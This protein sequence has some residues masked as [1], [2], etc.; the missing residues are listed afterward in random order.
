M[1]TMNCMAT[2]GYRS[3]LLT[4]DIVERVTQG[5]A[6]AAV[7]VVD[8]QHLGDGVDVECSS[9]PGGRVGLFVVIVGLSVSLAVGTGGVDDLEGFCVPNVLVVRLCCLREVCDVLALRTARR[10]LV[11]KRS[12]GGVSPDV[13]YCLHRGAFGAKDRKTLGMRM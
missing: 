5:V 13:W 7:R 10:V 6:V 1:N 11:G 3:G 12:L 8:A 2:R 9:I 4:A